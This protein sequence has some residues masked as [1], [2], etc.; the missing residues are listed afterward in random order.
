[1]ATLSKPQ[2]PGGSKFDTGNESIKVQGP[3]VRTTVSVELRHA[4]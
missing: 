2:R 4:T 1:M 3:N